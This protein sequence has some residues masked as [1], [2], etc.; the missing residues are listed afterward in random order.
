MA[1]TQS[2]GLRIFEH[3]FAFVEHCCDVKKKRKE[4]EVHTDTTHS[5]DG[6]KNLTA[7][8]YNVY[9]VQHFSKD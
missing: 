4:K 5:I 7:P 9:K 2:C 6:T 8:V 1:A 3:R